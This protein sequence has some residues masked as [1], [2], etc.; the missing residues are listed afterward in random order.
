M[1]EIRPCQEGDARALFD[2]LHPITRQ[3]GEAY[4]VFGAALY[5]HIRDTS[6]RAGARTGV[7]DGR[8][9]FIAASGVLRLEERTRR[10]SFVMAQCDGRKLAI[11][12]R[13]W[14]KMERADYPGWSFSVTSYS[15]HPLRD[16]FF[17]ALGLRYK[18][19]RPGFALF[20]G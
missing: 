16:R 17:A 19:G 9:A 4:K 15:L 18:G 13:K 20:V 7:I 12:A 5:P 1:I 3:E 14:A 11:A 10:T 8:V 6:E 2:D